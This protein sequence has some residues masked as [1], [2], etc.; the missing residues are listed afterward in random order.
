MAIK[1]LEILATNKTTKYELATY[2][3][4][5]V[6]R[7]DLKNMPDYL[8]ILLQLRLSTLRN[9]PT[10]SNLALLEPRLS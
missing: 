2:L 9:V 10:I 4:Y 6:G 5:N 1:V 8:A 3:L 7:W